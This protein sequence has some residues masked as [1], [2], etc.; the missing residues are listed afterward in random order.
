M[1]RHVSTLLCSTA[2]ILAACGGPSEPA[3]I[4]NGAEATALNTTATQPAA[5]NPAQ[6]FADTAAASDA[7][8]I[9]T[10]E[11]ALQKS[12]S[13]GI[14]RFAAQMIKAH[15]ES[16]AK[17]NAA[18]ASANPTIVPAAA[19]TNEQNTELE[20]LRAASGGSF[21]T[22]YVEQQRAAHTATLAAL[23]DYSANGEVATLKTFATEMVP[24]V[25]AH[26][27]MATSLKP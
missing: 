1:N 11:L 17:L 19:L 13:A 14:K 4:G 8:E 25:T 6:L 2:L 23:K 22:A 26:L 3:K 7:F 10:S 5:A 18:A 9:A 16:T 12:S 21:D 24:I 27:N 20:R 15:K